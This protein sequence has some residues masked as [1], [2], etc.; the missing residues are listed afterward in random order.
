MKF[1][2]P[3]SE[4]SDDEN[5]PQMKTVYEVVPVQWL[6]VN[7]DNDYF[8]YWPSTASQKTMNNLV[9]QQAPPDIENWAACP[10]EVIK[11]YGESA[12]CLYYGILC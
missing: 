2:E 6:D 12:L 10:C 3:D 7:E 8:C 11:T 5:G 4:C 1:L 9:K